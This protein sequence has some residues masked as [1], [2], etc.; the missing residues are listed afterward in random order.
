MHHAC[1]PK[2]ELDRRV[3]ASG[4]LFRPTP[5][6]LL[7]THFYLFRLVHTPLIYATV[8]IYSFFLSVYSPIIL[9]LLSSLSPCAIDQQAI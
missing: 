8:A 6:P 5:L 9:P 1:C 7:H 4:L 2:D 3:I